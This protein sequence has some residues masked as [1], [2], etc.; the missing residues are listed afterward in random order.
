LCH[1]FAEP[2][3]S[4]V[5]PG[6]SSQDMKRLAFFMR[7][8]LPAQVFFLSGSCFTAL[9]FLR[10][11]F[12]VPALA[13]LIYN[14]AIILG[15]LLSPV[16]AAFFSKQSL[17]E[18]TSQLGMTGYCLGVPIGAFLGAFLLPFLTARKGGISLSFRFHHPLMKAFLLTA[19]PLMLGQTVIML[20]EQFLRIFGSFLSEG[21]V[22]LLNY[23]RRLT[24]VPIGLVGQA[25]AVASYPFLVDLLTKNETKQFEETLQKA[26][27]AG[28]ALIIPCACWMFANALP[29]FTLIFHGGRF[30]LSETLEACPLLQIMLCAVPFW[31][32]YMILVRAFYAHQD[33]ITPALTGT[34]VTILVLPIYYYLSARLSTKAIAWTSA[35]SV[36]SYIL[37]LFF[38]WKKRYGKGALSGLFR[39][40]LKIFLLASPLAFFSFLIQ[41]TLSELLPFHVIVTAFLSLSVSGILFLLFFIPL[42]YRFVPDSRALLLRIGNVFTLCIDELPRL[43]SR[44]SESLCNLSQ[45]SRL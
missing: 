41:K 36:T 43:R 45:F 28:L 5:A 33:T 4:L 20:D 35:L 13:P 32:L 38:I 18:T 3:A 40:G 1:I 9:L 16:L 37:W 7:I 25:A 8:I 14:G 17:T 15:G 6:F 21:S 23:A 19:L 22:S 34:I 44:E 30:G 2:L 31:M 27:R 29:I 24:Q 10:K 42:A 12:M 26:F 39:L 11:Q